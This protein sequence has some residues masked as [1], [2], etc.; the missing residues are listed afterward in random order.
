MLNNENPMHPSANFFGAVFEKSQTKRHAKDGTLLQYYKGRYDHLKAIVEKERDDD[1]D[2]NDHRAYYKQGRQGCYKAC[3]QCQE[4][5][6][7]TSAHNQQFCPTC[8]EAREQ[9]RR[10]QAKRERKFKEATC[11]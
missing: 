2:C 1:E 9:K 7:A 11:Q 8:I 3:K 4:P 10:A 5:L 6:A